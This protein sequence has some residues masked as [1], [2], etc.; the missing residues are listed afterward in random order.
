VDGDGGAPVDGLVDSHWRFQYVDRVLQEVATD[1]GPDDTID[2]RLTLDRGEHGG[3]TGEAYDCD[4]DGA[5]EE[6]F[7]YVRDDLGRKR[8]AMLSLE[9]GHA[10]ACFN[11]DHRERLDDPEEGFEEPTWPI[12]VDWRAEFQ[13]LGAAALLD[14]PNRAGFVRYVWAD[15]VVTAE[16]WDMDGDGRVEEVIHFVH[17]PWGNLRSETHDDGPDG[18]IDVSVQYSYACWAAEVAPAAGPCGGEWDL[19]LDGEPDAFTTYVHD[20]DGRT[21]RMT[22]DWD[23]DGT[24]D[25]HFHYTYDAQ[26]RRITEEWDTRLDGSRDEVLT[27]H[28]EGE[29]RTHG[30]VDEDDDGTID[31]R[32]TYHYDDQGRLS[33]ERWDKDGDGEQDEILTYRYDDQGKL[34]GALYDDLRDEQPDETVTFVYDCEIPGAE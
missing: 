33:E 15:N 28:H 1:Y 24:I 7:H 22:A 26:G 8:M 14:D 21:V 34:A 13:A 3:I 16:E 17:D 2:A 31:G 4:A 27:I 32:A 9:P 18:R 20:L 23:D 6:R 5:P 11:E 12:L 29:R 30:D 19:D 10:A 25:N